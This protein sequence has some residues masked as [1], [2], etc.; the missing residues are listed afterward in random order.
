VTRRAAAANAA[1]VLAA[2]TGALATIRLPAGTRTAVLAAVGTA[3]VAS[4][5][6]AARLPE[7]RGRRARLPIGL[8]LLPGVALALAGGLAGWAVVEAAGATPLRNWSVLLAGGAGA[9][10]VLLALAAMAGPP[11]GASPPPPAGPWPRGRRRAR[12]TRFAP[13]ASRGPRA[14]SS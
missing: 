13:P 8:D 7:R 12:G 6:L 9:M 11:S 10:A 2:L 3:L 14:R 1:F 4:S 5:E